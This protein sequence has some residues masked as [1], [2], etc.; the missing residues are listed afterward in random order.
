MGKEFELKYLA[1]PEDLEKISKEYGNFHEIAMETHYYDTPDGALGTLRWTL[2]RRTENNTSVCCLK[3][4]GQNLIRG[5]WETEDPSIESGV[6]TLCR[7]DVPDGF[8]AMVSKGL[9]EVCGARFVRKAKIVATADGTAEI[10]LDQGVFLGNGQEQ[11]FSELEVELKSGS[12]EA[13]E[14]LAKII[15]RKYG[16]TDLWIS[17]YE[18]ALALSKGE[19]YGRT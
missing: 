18:R 1:S 2:R 3:T 9:T 6:R 17:K 8:E 19:S 15:S 10:A 4:P 16:L 13:A 12:R 14:N 5:E 11:A 7:M